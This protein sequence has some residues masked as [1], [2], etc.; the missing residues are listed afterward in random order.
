MSEVWLGVGLAF[1]SYM[2]WRVIARRLRQYS[3][4]AKDSITVPQFFE[5]RF[6]DKT[7]CFG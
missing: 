6:R 3:Y 1:G 4:A 7:D 2:S 5:N